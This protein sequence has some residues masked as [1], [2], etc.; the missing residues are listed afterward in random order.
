MKTMTN[1]FLGFALVMLVPALAMAQMEGLKNTTPEERATKLTSMMESELSLD[2]KT[3][4]AVSG[5]N[6]KY[7]KET[8]ALMESGGT[9]FGKIM[10][11]RKNE[12]AKDAELKGVLTPE[13]YS[14]YEQKKSAMRETM[15]QK[16]QAKAGASQ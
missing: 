2:Q 10:T 4:E 6:L 1:L 5:I 3:T 12:E 8:Q 13:Q 9:Q 14:Q 7:A 16:F 15:K 11:F